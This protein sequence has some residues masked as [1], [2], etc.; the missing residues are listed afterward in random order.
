M[1]YALALA[2]VAACC[3]LAFGFVGL[4]ERPQEAPARP[5]KTW[6]NK[7]N[8]NGCKVIR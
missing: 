7:N 6:A 3:L 2:A 5:Y 1:V 4:A 8:Y